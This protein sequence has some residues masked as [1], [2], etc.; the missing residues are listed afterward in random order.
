VLDRYPREVKLVFKNFPLNIHPFARKAAAAAL[1][2]H[3]QEKFRE[4]HE[5]LFEKYETLND[6]V[7]QGIA[8]EIGLDVERFNR[9]MA[10]AP[11]QGI[12]NRDMNEAR[13]LGV[14]GTP[15]IFINGKQLKERST[16]GFQ[17][18]IDAELQK[19]K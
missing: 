5:K 14:R 11:I 13:A 10:S 16:R 12:I 17:T 1:A 6:S 8:A 9:D 15:T 7:I 18:M 3:R 4:A 19:G 2:A